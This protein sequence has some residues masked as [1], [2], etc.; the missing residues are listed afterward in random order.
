[1]LSVLLGDGWIIDRAHED[2]FVGGVSNAFA[3]GV[4]GQRRGRAAGGIWRC[5]PNGLC[6]RVLEEHGR[7]YGKDIPEEIDMVAMDPVNV[8]TQC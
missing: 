4:T 7:V 6:K 1:M 2:G 8:Y 3:L 5:G